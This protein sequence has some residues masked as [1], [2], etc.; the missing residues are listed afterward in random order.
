M[1]TLRFPGRP[2]RWLLPGSTAAVVVAATVTAV[3]VTTV[4]PAAG[5]AGIPAFYVTVNDGALHTAAPQVEVHK[6][7]DGAVT[8]HLSDRRCLVTAQSSHQGPDLLTQ[9]PA[10]PQV[11]PARLWQYDSRRP[12]NMQIADYFGFSRG[13]WYLGNCAQTL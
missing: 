7:S 1:R 12:R 8:S 6:S 13:A 9:V 2:R 4:T 3:M 10:P 11:L 5:A